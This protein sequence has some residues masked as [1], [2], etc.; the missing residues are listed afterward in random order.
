MQIW[1]AKC[2]M[3]W[4]IVDDDTT[5]CNRA[6]ALKGISAITQ[7]TKR[8]NADLKMFLSESHNKCVNK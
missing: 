7:T 5:R 2:D 1:G 6:L 4:K 3:C 8:L